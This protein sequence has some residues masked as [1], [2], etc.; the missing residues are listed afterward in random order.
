[1][2]GC[3]LQGTQQSQAGREKGGAPREDRGER[4]GGD[5]RIIRRKFR[6]KE[7]ENEGEGAKQGKHDQ[8]G[9][10]GGAKKGLG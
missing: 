7:G 5:R 2:T 3:T 10:K 6:E 4:G 8:V 9:A 1:M